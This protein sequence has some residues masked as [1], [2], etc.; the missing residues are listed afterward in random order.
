MTQ[1]AAEAG[2]VVETIYEV[3][4]ASARFPA[5]I[6]AVLAG[7]AGRADIPVAEVPPSGSHR[8][9][10]ESPDRAVA[11]ATQPGI[12]RRSGPLLRRSGTAWRAILSQP[13]DEWRL[14]LDG[15]GRFVG[16]LADKGALRA[17]LSLEQ[18][19][20][21]VW[22]LC[23]LAIH[24]LLVVE[25]GWTSERYQAWLAGVDGATS[26]RSSVNSTRFAGVPLAATTLRRSGPEADA[27]ST[28]LQ[29]RGL[30]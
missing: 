5:V 27:L 11:V 2:V 26:R 14:A 12:H 16:M 7:G 25:R 9:R 22:T 28:E 30:E 15:Q 4:A 8:V 17:G 3:S 19:R 24:D 6:E 23:S 18:A 1:I 10:S 29:A 20:D 13:S 21:V